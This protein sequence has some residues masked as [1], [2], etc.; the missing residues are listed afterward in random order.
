MHLIDF[1]TRLFSFRYSA[2]H[3]WHFSTTWVAT[4]AVWAVATNSPAAMI[5]ADV[6]LHVKQEM[7]RNIG[8]EPETLDPALVESV[9]AFEIAS[10]LFEG[11]TVG[12]D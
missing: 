1:A 5:P 9:G 6:Q 4:V 8:A 3:K 7:T 2:P 12:A 10:D 11:L